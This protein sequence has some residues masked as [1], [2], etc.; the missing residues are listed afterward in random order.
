MSKPSVVHVHTAYD[1]PGHPGLD[2]SGMPSMTKQSE[3]EGCDVNRIVEQ[4]ARTGQLPQYQGGEFLD[5]SQMPD[6]RGA[7]EYGRQVER[8]FSQLPAKVRARFENDA[9]VFLDFASSPDSVAELQELGILEK[10]P[11][12]AP[13]PGVVA[14]PTAAPAA[15]S[16][17]AS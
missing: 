17:A 6:Y 12:A 2:C 16:A 7:V 9:A 4:F 14:P 13:A 1:P 10:P 15:S 5:V 8:Y 3:A 11:A